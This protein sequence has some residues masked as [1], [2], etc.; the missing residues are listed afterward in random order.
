MLF[1]GILFLIG[2]IGLVI[3]GNYANSS[4]DLQLESL[5]RHGVRDPGNTFV[6]I[7]IALA[8]IGL[9]ML[10]TRARKSRNNQTESPSSPSGKYCVRCGKSIQINAVF[11]PYCGSAQEKEASSFSAASTGTSPSAPADNSL[12]S[13]FDNDSTPST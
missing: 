11:C 1:F 13:F 9:L 3:F 10:F 8:V 2:G 6:Y 4:V 5:F 7:G 12:D